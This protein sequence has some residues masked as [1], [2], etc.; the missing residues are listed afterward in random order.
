M[1]TRSTQARS[2]VLRFGGTENILEGL[3]F[4]FYYDMF[5]RNFGST[6][7][8]RSW[9][10]P[11][12]S[13]GGL[14]TIRCKICTKNSQILEIHHLRRGYFASKKIAKALSRYTQQQD[15]MENMLRAVSFFFELQRWRRVGRVL[16]M[17]INFVRQRCVYEKRPYHIFSIL[18]SRQTGRMTF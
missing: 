14:C 13:S 16:G 7:P 9:S 6:V 15:R 1:A 8:G 17:K 12:R 3:A 10:N 5:K 2:Q 11:P 4:C 18:A